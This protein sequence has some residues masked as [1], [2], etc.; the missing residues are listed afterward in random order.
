[1]DP[2]YG[3]S[4]RQEGSDSPMDTW[5]LDKKGLPNKPGFMNRNPTSGRWSLAGRTV[6]SGLGLKED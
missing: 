5:I 4:G 3:E 6:Q 1:M 2:N